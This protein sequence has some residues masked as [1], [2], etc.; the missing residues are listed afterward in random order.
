MVTLTSDYEVCKEGST[1][2]SEQAKILELMDFRLATFKLQLKA[3]WIKGEGFENLAGEENEEEGKC[4]EEMLE[5][6]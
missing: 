3:S 1:L 2:T 4:D 5:D 6:Q